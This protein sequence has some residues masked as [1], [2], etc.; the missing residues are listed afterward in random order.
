MT[1]HTSAYATTTLSTTANTDVPAIND[2]I[3]AIS[4]NH[5]LPQ[6]DYDLVAAYTQSATLNRTRIV[7]PT[8]RQITLPF[9][10]PINA[11][12]T[13]ATDTNVADYRAVPFRIE[14]LE[15]LAAEMTSDIAMGN[16]TGITGIFLQDRRDPVPPGNCFT[17]R[18]TSTTASVA[19]TWTT[20]AV[21]W[22]DALPD[23]DYVCI[24]CSVVGVTEILFRIIFENQ[25]L[26]PGGVAEVL[27]GNR[28]HEMFRKGGLGAWGRFK[29][30]R[31]PIIQ[32]FNTAAVASHTVFLDF[33]RV[34]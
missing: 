26:R 16:E 33:V 28:S 29:S 30:T 1:F 14:G 3:I 11:G 9:L 18:G 10:R 31:M 19:L 15:E 4:N 34:R 20:I 7:S 25:V 22:Q 13:P 27:V 12:S 24:G 8:N 21:T 23:G 32:V 17:L 6:R 5:F 2:D